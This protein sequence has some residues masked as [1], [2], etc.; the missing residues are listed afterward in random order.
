MFADFDHLAHA[1]TEG[2]GTYYNEPVGN[3]KRRICRWLGHK[4]P[5][6]PAN[7]NGYSPSNYAKC[8]RCKAHHKWFVVGQHRF[9]GYDRGDFHAVLD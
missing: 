3:W 4:L 9:G 2:W 1:D 5:P 7:A 6:K 8:S